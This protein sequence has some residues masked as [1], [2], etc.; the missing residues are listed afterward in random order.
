M[1]ITAKKPTRNTAGRVAT[2]A[3]SAAAMSSR[4]RTDAYAA[5][6]R[7]HAVGRGHIAC[8]TSRMDAAA[9]RKTSGELRGMT[10]S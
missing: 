4:A 8:R 10:T 7:A 1:V 5:V 6:N 9:Y 3:R 2:N